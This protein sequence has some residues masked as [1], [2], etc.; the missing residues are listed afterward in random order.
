VGKKVRSLFY[1]NPA[2]VFRYHFTDNNGLFNALSVEFLEE[3]R[4]GVYNDRK[5]IGLSGI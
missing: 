4:G 1:F 2:L 3:A 5:I